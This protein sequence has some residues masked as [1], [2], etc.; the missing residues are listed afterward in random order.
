MS[1]DATAWTCLERSDGRLL[2][3]ALIS[4]LA[5]LLDIGPGGDSRDPDY[6]LGDLVSEMEGIASLLTCTDGCDA[7]GFVPH[8]PV[9]AREVIVG[10]LGDYAVNCDAWQES[11]RD[12][13]N[14]AAAAYYE[15]EALAA[16]AWAERIAA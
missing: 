10:V 5:F 1:T 16:R 8:V 15:A 12:E 4:R 6:G 11:R 3:R 9:D 2:Q 14:D 13:G 7:P